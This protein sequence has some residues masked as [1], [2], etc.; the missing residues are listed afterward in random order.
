M[1]RTNVLLTHLLYI[2]GNEDLRLSV[3]FFIIVMDSGSLKRSC[4]R[5]LT[6]AWLHIIR[7]THLCL[8]YGREIVG[9]GSMTAHY[10]AKGEW[11]E[12]MR[13]RIDAHKMKCTTVMFDG[14]SVTGSF[15]FQTTR[16]GVYEFMEKVPESPLTVLM[17][18]PLRLLNHQ[19]YLDQRYLLIV[20]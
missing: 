14:D 19:N 15:D 1:S 6:I 2:S 5:A 8:V 12:K 17:F 16:Q 9:P 13:V 7:P 11:N 18:C 10:C 20:W 3:L 4:A